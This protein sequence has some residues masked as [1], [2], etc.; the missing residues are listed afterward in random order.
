MNPVLEVASNIIPLNYSIQALTATAHNSS[1]AGSYYLDLLILIG[2]SLIF[3]IAA[4]LT[5]RRNTK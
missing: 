5:L 4:A 3:A 2:F 1:L